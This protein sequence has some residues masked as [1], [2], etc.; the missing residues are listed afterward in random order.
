MTQKEQIEQLQQAVAALTDA[1]AST[2]PGAGGTGNAP[3]PEES[4]PAEPKLPTLSCW[5]AT[6][7]KPDGKGHFSYTTKAG[8]TRRYRVLSEKDAIA[9]VK[10]NIAAGRIYAV[11]AS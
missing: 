1:V 7:V 8:Q 4:K 2:L 10:A 3:K 9:A 6:S 11:S 5:K